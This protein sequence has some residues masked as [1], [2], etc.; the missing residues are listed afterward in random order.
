MFYNK[1]GKKINDDELR[2]IIRWAIILFFIFFFTWLAFVFFV[3]FGQKNIRTNFSEEYKGIS[4]LNPPNFHSGFVYSIDADKYYHQM[5]SSPLSFD[6]NSVWTWNTADVRLRYS[7]LH[8]G[9]VLLGDVQDYD[10]ISVDRPIVLE[11]ALMQDLNWPQVKE[12]DFVLYQRTKKDSSITNWIRNYDGQLEIATLNFQS[13]DLHTTPLF[14]DL[15]QER[16]IRIPAPIKGNHRLLAY[17]SD[18]ELNLNFILE[19]NNENFPRVTISNA[20]NNTLLYNEVLLFD[21][22]EEKD[23]PRKVNIDLIDVPINTPL[24]ID[25]GIDND[26]VVSDFQIVSPYLLVSSEMKFA[27]SEDD[28]RIELFTT[29]SHGVSLLAQDKDGL[30][31]AS[32]NGKPLKLDRKDFTFIKGG[33]LIDKIYDVSFYPS[34]IIAGTESFFALDERDFGLYKF[35]TTPRVENLQSL[36]NIDAILSY[37]EYKQPMF[38]EN[39]RTIEADFLVREDYIK[40]DVATFTIHAFFPG[41]TATMPIQIIDADV[42]LK[43]DSWFRNDFFKRFQRFTSSQL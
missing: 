26:D 31:E 18:D 5:V 34:N 42:K 22:K 17:T 6:V 15:L 9:N 3:P 25:I 1:E 35:L 36:E 13:V 11:A 4:R 19:N 41:S 10:G 37:R 38:Q 24:T 2:L 43:K 14:A 30:Q 21:D 7:S 20:E 29:D 40:K 12:G 8:R 27:S 28:Q 33:L 32:V 16:T 39:E 23:I